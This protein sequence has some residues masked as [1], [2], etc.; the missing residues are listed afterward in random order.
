[1]ETSPYQQFKLIVLEMLSLSKDAIHMHVGLGVFVLAILLWR[2]GRVDVLALLP[3]FLV[4]GVMEALDLFDDMASLGYLRW[5]ASVHDMVNTTFWP[6]FSA[7]M[8][9]LGRGKE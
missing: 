2:R 3:V 4:A 6:T 8:V 5:S 1:M 9:M 7:V